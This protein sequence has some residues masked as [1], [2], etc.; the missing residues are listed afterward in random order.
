[1]REAV[2][3]VGEVA[4]RTGVTVATLHFYERRGLIAS[5]RTVGNQRRYTRDVLR[6]VS[7]VRMAQRVG[8][9]LAA[10]GEALATLPEGRTPDRQDWAR[11]SA[12]WRADLDERIAALTRLRDGLADCIGCGC[13]SLDRCALANPDDALAAEGPGARRL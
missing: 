7:F 1:M 3:S 4:R 9:P 13:L 8:V 6:R 5:V 10:V 11:L 2:L 12:S